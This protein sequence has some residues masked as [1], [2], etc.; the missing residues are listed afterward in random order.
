MSNCDRRRSGYAAQAELARESATFAV[1]WLARTKTAMIGQLPRLIYTVHPITSKAHKWDP[2][3]WYR[4]TAEAT[5]LDFPMYCI[6]A[7]VRSVS[8]LYWPSN[9]Y[10]FGGT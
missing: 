2:I 7:F 8:S 1:L 10:H 9:M 5:I 3:I 4:T 6:G